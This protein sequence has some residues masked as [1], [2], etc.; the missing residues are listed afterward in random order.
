MDESNRKKI[1]IKE[2]RDWKQSRLLPE[3]YC[4]FL[5]TL[6][7]EGDFNLLNEELKETKKVKKTFTPVFF[8][9]CLLPISFLVTYFTE[10]NL[11][12]QIAIFSVFIIIC[13]LSSIFLKKNQLLQ[14][15][16]S[17]IGA[18][19]FLNA[20]VQLNSHFNGDNQFAL[21]VIVLLNCLIWLVLGIFLK[22]NYFLFASGLGIVLTIIAFFR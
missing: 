12:L 4:N 13:V 8:I 1:I 14:H 9:F 19:I 2:I 20:T 15:F 7:T 18:L 5:L 22:R 10:I 3:E 11:V 6:Y 16:S 21:L 17:I